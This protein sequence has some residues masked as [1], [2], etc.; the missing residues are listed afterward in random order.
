MAIRTVYIAPEATYAVAAV[1]T[2]TAMRVEKW[3]PTNDP[4]LD[5]PRETTGTTIVDINPRPGARVLNFSGEVRGYFD[6]MVHWFNMA[7]GNPVTATPYTGA[8]TARVHTF[9]PGGTPKSYTILWKQTGSQGTIWRRATGCMIKNLKLNST[10]N[11]GFKLNFSGHGQGVSTI[12]APTPV[13]DLT[14]SY[15]Q[16]F[17]LDQQRLLLN[18]VAWLKP[19]KFDVTVDNGL[20]PDYSIQ[21]SR[22][23]SRMKLGDTKATGD[24]DAFWDAY[25]GS[26]IEASDA[27]TQLLNAVK[28]C[29]RDSATAIGTGLVITGVAGT[30]TV[31]VTTTSAHG[32]ATGE[33]VTIAGVVGYTDANST[34]IITV[35]TSTTFTLNGLT[36]AQTYTSG[37]TVKLNPQFI[38]TYPKPFIEAP[39]EDDTNT[40]PQEKGKL[41]FAYDGTLASAGS[42]VF[43]NELP[44]ATFT[45]S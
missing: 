15:N 9:L 23:P 13:S 27:A 11:A 33:S 8:G 37:G 38:C 34:F 41:I 22:D 36:S 4:K 2:Y 31:T 35:V 7:F 39:S 16:P 18:G 26:L 20:I 3:T 28:V 42:F 25:S 43:A 17:S 5:I 19:K 32:F 44:A 12:S 40:D 14:A 24:I 10:G 45:G 30:S 1:G 29:V 21:E 6:L